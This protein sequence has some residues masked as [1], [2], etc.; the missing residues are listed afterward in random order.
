MAVVA[1]FAAKSID[2]FFGDYWNI[3][4]PATEFDEKMKKYVVANFGVKD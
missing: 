4:S 2:A 1:R 3:I